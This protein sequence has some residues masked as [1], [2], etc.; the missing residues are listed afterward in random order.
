MR[1]AQERLRAVIDLAVAPVLKA[2]G[3]KKQAKTFWLPGEGAWGVANFQSSARGERCAGRFTVNL[4]VALERL[5]DVS[6]G[7][8]GERPKESDCHMRERLGFLLPDRLPQDY[9]WA[10]DP[11]TDLAR[12]GD[13]MAALMAEVVVPFL[14]ARTS[15]KALRDRW[16]DDVPG[17]GPGELRYLRL[18][19]ERA[20]PAE[21]LEDVRREE[22]RRDTPGY[23]EERKER[24]DALR[25]ALEA[26]DNP[27]TLITF[28]R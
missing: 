5:R 1:S 21:R 10:V 22:E 8:T 27:A 20:G 25:R 13:E 19:L 6:V 26:A 11:D 12:L 16:L 28:R 2:H 3:F 9:W 23:L 24:G 17:M 15:E 7:W 18:L 4:G 14:V